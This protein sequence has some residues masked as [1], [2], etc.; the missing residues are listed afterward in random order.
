MNSALFGLIGTLRVWEM[1]PWAEGLLNTLERAV[2]NHHIPDDADRGALA[3]LIERAA[4][5]DER[6]MGCRL[7]ILNLATINL[8]SSLVNWGELIS[9]LELRYDDPFGRGFEYVP[10]SEDDLYGPINE[11]FS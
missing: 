11:L 1:E 9:V 7:E 3:E 2:C 10:F 5:Q 6:S 4:S 8:C